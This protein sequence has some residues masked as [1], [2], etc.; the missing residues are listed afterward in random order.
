MAND[1]H[2]NI[3]TAADIEKYHKGQLSAKRMHDIEKAAL[4]DPFLADALEG[5]ALPGL[6]ID[7]DLEELQNRLSE[8]Q[9]D[10]AKVVSMTKGAGSFRWLRAAAMVV[11]L[12]GAALVSYQLL[13]KPDN[14]E[15]ALTNNPDPKTDQV[16]GESKQSIKD[17]DSNFKDEVSEKPTIETIGNKA[18]E[19]KANENN[20]KTL[21]NNGSVT[22]EQATI[23]Q[24]AGDIPVIKTAP[25]ISPEKKPLEANHDTRNEI[26]KEETAPKKDLDINKQKEGREAFAKI[27]REK[28]SENLAR[29]RAAVIASSKPTANRAD[30][31][32]QTNNFFRGRVTDAN[33]NPLPFANI[34]NTIDNVGTYTDAKGNFTLVSPSDSLMNVQVRALGFE[35]NR[36][37]LRSDISSNQ[38]KLQEDKTV[39]ARVL[40]TVKRNYAIRSRDASMTFEEPE[41]ADGWS[42]Y[43]SYIANNLSDIPEAYVIKKNTGSDAVELSFEVNKFGDPINIRIEK[44]LCDK[45]DKEAIRL[46]KE[47]PKWKRKAR[48]G[49]RTTVTVPFTK[50]D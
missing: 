21:T 29:Q 17:V 9:K 42:S 20:D 27:A 14:A 46:I 36:I 7:A 11:V 33:N 35:N 44:S 41:P 4:D 8:K 48:K 30:N 15:I 28:D 25:A 1:N 22:T 32:Y 47:G 12:L 6:N 31:S 24:Q 26:V 16:T 5:F 39:S 10:Q 50:I 45:C 19:I 23:N 40:D 3:F 49:K 2:I 34:V 38:I 43:D 18:P 13:F 37:E